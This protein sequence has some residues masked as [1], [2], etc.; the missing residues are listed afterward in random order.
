MEFSCI[1]WGDV[2]KYA[3][4]RIYKLQKYARLTD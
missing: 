1:M 3:T 4:E 2:G